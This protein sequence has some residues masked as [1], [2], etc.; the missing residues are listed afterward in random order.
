MLNA[1]SAV[2]KVDK[3]HDRKVQVVQ[4]T[5]LRDKKGSY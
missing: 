2:K 5:P 4:D 3:V 1:Q